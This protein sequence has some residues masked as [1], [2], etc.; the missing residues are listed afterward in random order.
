MDYNQYIETIKNVLIK[1]NSECIVT[2]ERNG[3]S[4]FVPTKDLVDN[5]ITPYLET[6]WDSGEREP[7]LDAFDHI[8]LKASKHKELSHVEY[9]I[10]L[11]FA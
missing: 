8:L 1:N 2:R 6:Q 4:V 11:L 9:K 7:E 10:A 3:R 5:G